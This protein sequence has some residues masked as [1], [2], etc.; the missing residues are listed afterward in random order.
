VIE[1]GFACEKTAVDV[2]VQGELVFLPGQK[3]RI[4]NVDKTDGTLDDTTGSTGG[5][6]PMVFTAPDVAGGTTSVNK[7]GYKTTIICGSTVAGEPIPPHFQFK[8]TAKTNEGQRISVD[9][10]GLCPRIRGKFGHAHTKTFPVTFGMNEKGGMNSIELQM[11]VDMAI[12]PLY[13]DIADVPG[14]RVLMKVDS[15]WS[16]THEYRDVG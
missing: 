5:R 11:Y 16:W 9:W 3:E 13:P 2:E 1:L 8:S 7:C 10:F 6:P 4:I 12:F 15:E 14:K